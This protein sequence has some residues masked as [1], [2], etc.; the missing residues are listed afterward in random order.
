MKFK[1]DLIYGQNAENAFLERFPHL[2]KTDGRTGDFITPSGKILE[3]K[4]DRHDP[5]IFRNLIMERYSRMGV[6]GGPWQAKSHN[7]ELFVYD[8]P[9]YGQI[10]VFDV[11]KLVEELETIV[12]V[13]E[14]PLFTIDNGTHVT[15]YYKIKINYLTD[16]NLGVG[17]IC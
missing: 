10:Y 7:C 17:A 14:L 1:N 5:R 16:I 4:S 15:H 6:D 2:T 12:K 9:K 3:L 11:N 13:N 8:F